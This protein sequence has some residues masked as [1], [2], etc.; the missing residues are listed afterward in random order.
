MT[1]VEIQN[2]RRL[3]S[4]ALRNF[5]TTAAQS[6]RNYLVK[7]LHGLQE[8]ERR[9]LFLEWGFP[10]LH[11]FCV[12]ALGYSEGSAARR[13]QASRLLKDVPEVEAKPADGTLS[14]SVA[15]QAQTFF[16]RESKTAAAYT[17]QQKREVLAT[18]NHKTSRETER[19]LLKLSP[20]SLPQERIRQVS[21]EHQELRLILDADLLAA[22]EEFKALASHQI[23]NNAIPTSCTQSAPGHFQEVFRL[24]LTIANEALRKKKLG[25]ERKPRATPKKPKAS[26]KTY[27]AKQ[28]TPLIHNATP[29]PEWPVL[30]SGRESKLKVA[31]YSG[32]GRQ[33]HQHQPS[34]FIP[35]AIKRAVWERDGGNCAYLDPMTRRRCCSRVRLQFDHFPTP[36]ARGG[37]STFENLRLACSRHNAYASEKLFGKYGRYRAAGPENTRLIRAQ[38]LEDRPV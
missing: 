32:S 27:E 20:Q 21:P 28:P 10:S 18:L 2:L 15:A 34:R 4:W 25:V 19:E 23:G 37:E 22:I 36:F 24:A 14:L 17:P 33:Q 26:A 31:L 5:V 30:S 35:V 1:T 29:T 38:G 16:Y 12:D 6:E 11:Q 3:D 13:V 7:V 8:I 9:R